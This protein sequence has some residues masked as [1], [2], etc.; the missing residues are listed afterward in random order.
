MWLTNATI[1]TSCHAGQHSTIEHREPAILQPNITYKDAE[2]NENTSL[3]VQN[4]KCW[5]VASQYCVST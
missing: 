1:I 4:L 2:D 3:L 5:L